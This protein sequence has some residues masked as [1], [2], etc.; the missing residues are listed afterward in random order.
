MTET[1]LRGNGERLGQ[2]G[3][4]PIPCTTT[5]SRGHL[6]L[7]KNIIIEISKKDNFMTKIT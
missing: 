1:Y 3:P 6:G 4:R 5:I 2:N 7:N